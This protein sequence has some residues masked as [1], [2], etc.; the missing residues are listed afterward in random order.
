VQC[1]ALDTPAFAEGTGLDEKTPYSLV[2]AA[3]GTDGG[4]PPRS[5]RRP[6]ILVVDADSRRRAALSKLIAGKGL[7]AVLASNGEE[8]LALVAG[9]G[10]VLVVCSMVMPRMDGLEFLRMMRERQPLI[11]VVVVA[12][13]DRAID[14]VYLRGADLLGAARSF[15]WP[16]AESAF[17]DCVES[18][19]E[20]AS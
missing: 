15:S 20:Q 3:P 16:L 4:A 6:A 13:G 19:L 11:P 17:L 10:V 12:S 5:G 9:G 1:L 8:A 7:T 2:M 14:Q 18:L